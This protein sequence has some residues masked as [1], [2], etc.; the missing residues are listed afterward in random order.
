MERSIQKMTL[1]GY[2]HFSSKEKK[3][4]Y[5]VVQ[6]LYNS[7]DIERSNNKATMINIYTDDE[8][9]KKVCQ[10][11]IGEVLKVEMIPNLETGKIYYKVVL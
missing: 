10:M 11:S 4:L 5:Y 2:H 8:T 6:V 1:I 3:Q 9:Y 7:L